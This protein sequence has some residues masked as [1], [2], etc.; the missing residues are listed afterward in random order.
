M[1]KLCTPIH[2]TGP[3]NAGE[4]HLFDYLQV[5]LPDSYY[6][7]PNG[8]YP[9]INPNGGTQFM[10]CDCIVVAPHAIY[11]IE[12]KDYKG[13]LEAYDSAWF[14]NDREIKNPIKG[15]T[16]KGKVLSDYL[17][18]KDGR[19]K[20]AWIESIVTLSNLN[21]NKSGFE[22][23]S[24]SDNKTFLLNEELINFIKEPD[25]LPHYVP[26]GAIAS[27]QFDIVDYL[28][29]SSVSRTH[30]RTN[31]C[32]MIIDEI[33]DTT[34]DYIEYLCHKKFPVDKKYKVRDYALNKAGMSPSQIEKHEKQIGRASCR[35]R[36]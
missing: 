30:I 17:K 13:R 3:V 5:N 29:G 36:V 28:M 12:N 2:S 32:G 25:R 24:A 11:L 20:A 26:A 15:V 19:W 1:A 9:Y 14:H 21:Q 6:I 35:E 8:E 31:V 16:F 10:E 7:I 23:G 33:L 27:Y 34:D 4:K 22:A 18:R